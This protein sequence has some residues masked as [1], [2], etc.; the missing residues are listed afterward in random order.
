MEFIGNGGECAHRLIDLDPDR[1]TAESIFQSILENIKLFL[2]NGIVHGDLSAY[3]I[4]YWDDKAFIIDF[5]QCID[6]RN[7]PN[8]WEVLER[9]LNNVINYF[10]KYIEMDEEKVKEEFYKLSH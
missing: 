9:D 10:K 2:E 1:E 8:P 4:L 5:P 6:I 3:N 7:Y